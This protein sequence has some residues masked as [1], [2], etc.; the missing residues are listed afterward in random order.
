MGSCTFMSILVEDVLFCSQ[1]FIA[2]TVVHSWSHVYCVDEDGSSPGADG[3][4]GG[5]PCRGTS[6]EVVHH[7]RWLVLAARGEW[8]VF[9]ALS[10][11]IERPLYGS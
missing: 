10:L 8:G 4:T 3:W 6:S 5:K 11:L 7:N 1:S 2:D 9:T